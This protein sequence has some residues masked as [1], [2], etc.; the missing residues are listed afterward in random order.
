MPKERITPPAKILKKQ[1]IVFFHKSVTNA[2]LA[3][4]LKNAQ[5]E[6]VQSDQTYP[7]WFSRPLIIVSHELVTAAL[8]DFVVTF[9]A[10]RGH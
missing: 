7:K 5:L 8:L 10:T 6:R 9:R 2:V 4:H 3:L 1:K